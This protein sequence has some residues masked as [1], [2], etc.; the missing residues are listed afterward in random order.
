LRV[1]LLH[2]DVAPDAPPDEID[3]LETADAIEIA[4]KAC[5]HDVGRAAFTRDYDQL[6]A[7]VSGHD[8]VFNLVEAVDGLGSLAGIAPRM[9][10][11]IGVPFT[12]ADAV[13]LAV[14]SDKPLSK[15]KLAEVG[16]PT[17][18]WCE[19]PLWD[20]LDHDRKYIVKSAT[21]DASI[22]I[23]AD[24]IV[25]GLDRIKARARMCSDRWGGRW[26]AELFV[27]GR[28][29]NIA[30]LERDGEPWVLPL[31]EMTFE[32]W[33]EDRPRIVGY[34]AKWTENTIEYDQTIRVFGHE[35]KEPALAALI[36]D[37]VARSWKAFDLRG[38][39][40]VDLRVDRDGNPWILEINPNPSI[41]PFCGLT[42]AA[43]QAGLSYEQLIDAVLHSALS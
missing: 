16:V 27:D 17:P 35:E 3:T 36:R 24:S 2:S 20:G 40:R 10:D 15:R 12:G 39:A 9:L 29:F 4:L 22:G 6:E 5:G 37:Y 18:P 14:T 34:D 25:T 41:A 31:A 32:N 19:P 23:D 28:E 8:A 42:A 43:E 13:A 1:L 30:V 21:E 7:I 11:E 33:P 38:S 26:F